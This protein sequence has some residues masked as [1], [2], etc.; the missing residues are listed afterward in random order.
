MFRQARDPAS[1]QYTL[2]GSTTFCALMMLDVTIR[3][4]GNRGHLGLQE[5]VSQHD[6]DGDN[7]GYARW[8]VM[9]RSAGLA[10]PEA[11]PTRFEG[12][13]RGQ[14]HWTCGLGSLNRGGA[15]YGHCK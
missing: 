12:G 5:E 10:K 14:V 4:G 15:T 7:E 2:N 13:D 6:M 8:L 9:A 1:R 11:M 3:C